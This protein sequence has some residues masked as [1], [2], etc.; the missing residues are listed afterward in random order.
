MTFGIPISSSS[1]SHG[2]RNTTPPVPRQ[3]PGSFSN[4]KTP[5][6]PFEISLIF[7]GTAVT[8]R[9]WET[10]S[11]M[12]LIHEA[13]QIF[14]IGPQEIILVLFGSIPASLRRDGYLFG[15]PR[16]DPGSRVMVFHAPRPTIPTHYPRAQMAETRVTPPE[17]A[18]PALS[19]KLLSTFKLPKFDG[20]ARSWKLWEKS[21]QRFLGLHQG[22]R[23]KCTRGGFPGGIVDHSRGKGS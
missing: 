1:Q 10:M 8:C 23:Q 2:A 22:Q 12:Q 13:G 6:L 9:A 11:V 20:V 16:V 18:I 4:H 15:P 19:S 17:V 21:F 5:D 7:E 14:G 3:V